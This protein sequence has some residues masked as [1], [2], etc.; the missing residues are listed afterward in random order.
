MKMSSETC[1]N[2]PTK[3]KKIR[4][5]RERGGVPHGQKKSARQ[6]TWRCCLKDWQGR[7]EVTRCD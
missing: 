7:F 6:K 2:Y 5:R 1:R 3:R 4:T